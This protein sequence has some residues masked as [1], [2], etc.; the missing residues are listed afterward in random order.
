MNNRY[1]SVDDFSGESHVKITQT[2]QNFTKLSSK[3]KCRFCGHYAYNNCPLSK[4]TV[5]AFVVGLIAATQSRTV[6]FIER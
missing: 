4:Q 1:G 6:G 2:E 5:T 3:R